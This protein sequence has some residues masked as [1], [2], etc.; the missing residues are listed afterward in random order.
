MTFLFSNFLWLLPLITVPILIHLLKKQSYSEVNFS[1]LKFF[2]II[3]SESIKKNNITNIILLILR[4]L[5]LLSIVMIMSRP[6][7]KGVTNNPGLDSRITIIIDN[8]ISNFYNMSSN[9][10]KFINSF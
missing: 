1:T 9:F 3:Q 2:N 10:S 5:I 6:V 4:T 7:Y 8:S